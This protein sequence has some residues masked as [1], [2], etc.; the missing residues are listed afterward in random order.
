[1]VI[2]GLPSWIG[3]SLPL[4]PYN[5]SVSYRTC[6]FVAL[7]TFCWSLL[8]VLSLTCSWNGI[9]GGVS[10]APWR[11]LANAGYFT[12][13]PDLNIL[14]KK[15]LPVDIFSSFTFVYL[16]F[17]PFLCISLPLLLLL[18]LFCIAFHTFKLSG[19]A[20][21]GYMSWKNRRADFDVP[22]RNGKLANSFR[23]VGRTPKS[24]FGQ[25]HV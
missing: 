8:F 16:S 21:R 22:Y 7:F 10:L 2:R 5:H 18:K 25:K 17:I 24:S 1:M 4:L 20:L 23:E 3:A 19:I 6:L 13:Q 12:N 14:S 15:T 11:H 9:D